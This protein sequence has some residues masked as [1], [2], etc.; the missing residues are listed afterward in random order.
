MTSSVDRRRM[1]A[2]SGALVVGSTLPSRL[3]AAPTYTPGGFSAERL[4]AIPPLLQSYV[5]DGSIAGVVTLLCRKGEI[6]QVNALGYRDVEARKPMRRDTVFRLAS[7]TKPITCA[8]VLTLVDHGKLN[9]LDPIDRWLPELASP[10]VL[11]DPDGPLGHTHASSRSITVVDLLTHRG[12]FAPDTA[13]GPLGQAMASLRLGDPTFD[14][15]LAQLG[16]LP[17]AYD[18]G[19]QFSYGTSHNALGA[20]ISRVS[21]QSFESYLRAE[22]FGPLGMTDTAFWVP[23]TKQDRIARMYGRDPQTGRPV[24][25]QRPVPTA[26]P[27]FQ[28]G[29]GGLLSTVGDYLKFSRMLLGKGQLDGVR[30]LTRTTVAMMTTNWLSP[31]QLSQGFFGIADFWASQGFGL[32]V[33]VTTDVSRLHPMRN[34]YSSVGSFGWPGSSGVYWRADPV[35]DLVTIYFIQTANAGAPA[36]AVGRPRTPPVISFV[37]AAYRAIEA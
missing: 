35:E 13:T 26:A 30:I 3:L 9:L 36:G 1:L 29:A 34:P 12:G 14:S 23:P 2:G 18:P 16:S 20:L 24:S 6:A 4:A 25:V 5:D 19:A 28:S 21:G 32:G 15:W 10:R 33:S 37:N 17:L 7:S 22:I 8:A 27:Q 31:T 11:D